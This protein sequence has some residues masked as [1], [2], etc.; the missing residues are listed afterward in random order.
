[1]G[2]SASPWWSTQVTKNWNKV[3]IKFH[4]CVWCVAGQV[5]PGRR[6]TLRLCTVRPIIWSGNM[7]LVLLWMADKGSFRKRGKHVH[8]DLVYR[9]TILLSAM[10]ASYVFAQLE[11]FRIS[12][13]ETC[14]NLFF[15]HQGMGVQF[16]R[17]FPN[18]LVEFI[19]SVYVQT[20]H[21]RR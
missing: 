7:P 14:L 6:Q 10:T 12:L 20:V 13:T 15:L 11:S 5:F 18:S 16:T 9:S 4:C 1:M 8:V 3:S 19:H 21:I 2:N 17:T